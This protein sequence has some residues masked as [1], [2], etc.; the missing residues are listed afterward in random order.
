MCWLFLLGQSKAQQLVLT[1][2][3]LRF[4]PKSTDG[5]SLTSLLLRM[6]CVQREVNASPVSQAV[7]LE[8]FQAFHTHIL[9]PCLYEC[10]KQV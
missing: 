3:M 5:F 8:L 4:F 9:Y 2:N 7:Y 10:K 1:A 6:F